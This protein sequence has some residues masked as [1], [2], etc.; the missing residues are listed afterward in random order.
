HAPNVAIGSASGLAKQH[1][2]Y[3]WADV[4]VVPL[5]PNF[6]ASG[7][8]VML[9]AAALGKPMIVSDVGGLTDYFPHDT[10]AYV[11]PFDA[12]AMRDAA[13]RF[14]AEP[15]AALACAR[16]AV[17]RLRACDLT[18]QAFAEQ[19]VRITRELLRRRRTPA[20]AAGVAMPLADSRPSSR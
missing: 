1:E 18:T 3:A 2:L 5:R 10:A 4:I 6:H 12:Q 19:H 20:A 16:A 11:P 17:E 15:L 7:I 8:T 14:A 13:D 9:E